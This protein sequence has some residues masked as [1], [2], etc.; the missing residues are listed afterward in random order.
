MAEELSRNRR[1]YFYRDQV[2]TIGAAFAVT[3]V[4]VFVLG[5]ITGRRFEQRMRA[6]YA[7]AAAQLPLKAQ[8]DGLDSARDARTREIPTAEKRS[9]ELAPLPSSDEGTAGERK[10]GGKVTEADSPKTADSVKKTDKGAPRPPAAKSA[11][12][13]DKAALS[14]VVQAERQISQ[15]IKKESSERAWTVQIKSSPDKKFADNWADR[16]KAKGYDA[17]VVDADV[18]GQTWYRV[19]VGHFAAREEAEALRATLESKEG[20]SGSFVAINESADRVPTK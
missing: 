20:L 15:P 3:L 11:K 14:P 5:I 19:R 7:A 1:Y 13:T 10:V 2:I 12:S 6:E 9:S 17:F 8:S 16:L 4:S 18:K